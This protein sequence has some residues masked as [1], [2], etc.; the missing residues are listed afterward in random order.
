M[1]VKIMGL[2]WDLTED[3][4]D[5]D[6]K[7]VLLAYADHADHKGYNI[8][9]AILTISEKTL[10]KERQTQSITKSLN[11]KGF[12]VADGRGPN[13]TNKWRIPLDAGGA[14]I[15][16]V[17]KLRGA[18]SREEG[19]AVSRD[20][21][22]AI[23]TAPESSFNHPE[24]S[25]NDDSDMAQK[26]KIL[27]NLYSDNV[28]PITVLGADLIRNMAIDYPE[29]WYKPAFEIAVKNNARNLNYINTILRGWKEHEF[30]W[31]PARQST[32]NKKQE[33]PPTPAADPAQLEILRAQ[34]R[35][36]FAT[37]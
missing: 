6:E 26:I 13:G 2:V 16:P 29:S 25:D 24:S 19:G 1:S 22:G 36:E 23:A 21:R 32:R 5:R 14:K 9:P 3:Q 4:I 34:A 37:S 11:E 27:S 15:A 12:L 18:V 31:K 7:Y 8:Y 35:K 17:Q 33:T 30:G 20:E 28:G 10:Y